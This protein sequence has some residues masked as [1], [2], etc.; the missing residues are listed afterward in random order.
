MLERF[1]HNAR[2]ADI[3]LEPREAR[4]EELDALYPERFDA[5]ICRGCS[6]IY[7][8][9]FDDNA[10]P[11]RTAME[12]S[13]RSFVH[14]L[15]PGGR[16]YVDAPHAEGLDDEDS[17]WT[18]HPPRTMHGRNIRMRERVVAD[19]SAGIRRWTVQLYIDGDSFALER[20]SHYLPHAEL[21]GLLQDAGLEDVGRADVTGERYAVFVGQKR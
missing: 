19:L 20:K 3:E 7:A 21:V 2:A 13:I 8:G 18:E 1:C 9:T 14:C 4:W 5:V 11:D 17:Q 12:S 15:R 16:V 6:L 10:E